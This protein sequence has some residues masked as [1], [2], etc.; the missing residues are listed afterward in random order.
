V[1]KVKNI[2]LLPDAEPNAEDKKPKEDEVKLSFG[3]QKDQ[4]S[5]TPQSVATPSG[6]PIFE[7]R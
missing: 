2:E 3:Y 1:C 4:T 5:A 6:N 7:C